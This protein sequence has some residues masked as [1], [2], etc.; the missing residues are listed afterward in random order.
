MRKGQTVIE[1][2]RLTQ[3]EWLFSKPNKINNFLYEKNKTQ[4][5]S[6]I[7]NKMSTQKD[8]FLI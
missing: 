1:K 5:G 4:C 8:I 7:F 2:K 3:N 6:K